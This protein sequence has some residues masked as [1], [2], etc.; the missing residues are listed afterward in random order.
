MSAV[1]RRFVAQWRLRPLTAE[2]VAQVADVDRRAYRFP[3]SEAVFRD[4]LSAG[5][6]GWVMLVGSGDALAG[7]VVLSVGAA[8]AHI[9]NLC[10]APEYQRRGFG[11]VLLKHA[12]DAARAMDT[13]VV[14]LEVRR[15]NDIAMAL[16]RDVGFRR[17]GVR[18]GYYPD[19]GNREDAFV[20]ALELG[21][22]LR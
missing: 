17:I 9:L 3:W 16:Y 21:W 13:R 5:Y 10:V 18:R 15:S 6:H 1:A 7:Y 22:R 11:R 12:L 2:R 20:Y 4:C 8:E 19:D 14:F